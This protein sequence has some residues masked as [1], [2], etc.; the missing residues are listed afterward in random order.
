[1]SDMNSTADI[2]NWEGALGPQSER[3][4]LFYELNAGDNSVRP[5]VPL[6]DRSTTTSEMSLSSLL[7]KANGYWLRT[8]PK[9]RSSER[10]LVTSRTN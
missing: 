5:L 6:L 1:M 2:E 8:I 10:L 7:L 9:A 4:P 3:E